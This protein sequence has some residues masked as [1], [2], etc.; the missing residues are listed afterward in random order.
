M[1]LQIVEMVK[2]RRM[3]RMVQLEYYDVAVFCIGILGTEELPPS[4]SI[5]QLA[6]GMNVEQVKNQACQLSL[7]AQRAVNIRRDVHATTCVPCADTCAL[8]KLPPG[9]EQATTNAD[10][11]ASIGCSHLS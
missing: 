11:H 9:A 8:R 6:L 4:S 10:L 2:G 7:N 1:R 3:S 5:R